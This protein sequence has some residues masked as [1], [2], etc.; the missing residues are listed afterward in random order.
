MAVETK[1]PFVSAIESLRS[2]YSSLWDINE[3]L[4]QHE[5]SNPDPGINYTNLKLE[6]KHRRDSFAELTSYALFLT[7]F[8]KPIDSWVSIDDI[9]AKVRE[10]S[11]SVQSDYMRH[12]R[13][14]QHENKMIEFLAETWEQINQL[15]SFDEAETE[16]Q[17]KTAKCE[18]LNKCLKDIEGIFGGKEINK[19]KIEQLIAEQKEKLEKLKLDLDLLMYAS[20]TTAKPMDS[21]ELDIL[22]NMQRKMNDKISNVETEDEKL[23]RQHEELLG[24]KILGNSPD[25]EILRLCYTNNDEP[26]SCDVKLIYD[27]RKSP[28]K[29]VDINIVDC[30][31]DAADLILT[32]IQVNSFYEVIPE[33]IERLYS[34]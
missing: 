7:Q 16:V 4:L 24:V 8:S 13:C 23:L 33:L 5:D 20:Q 31:V 25:C 10:L 15:S 2:L 1:K 18:E 9:K 3:Q 19:L 34:S 29:L 14:E 22:C 12:E 26:K 28:K 21:E 32:A 11:E 27:V 6:I 17:A 30:T